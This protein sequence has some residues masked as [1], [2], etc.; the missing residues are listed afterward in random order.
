MLYSSWCEE[1]RDVEVWKG[2]LETVP[3][4]EWQGLALQVAVIMVSDQPSKYTLVLYQGVLT[5]GA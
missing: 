2:R 4:V 1:V 5:L 3:N